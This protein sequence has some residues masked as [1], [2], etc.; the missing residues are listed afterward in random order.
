MLY[1]NCPTCGN[2]L[3]DKQLIYRNEYNEISRNTKMTEEEK[4]EYL[5]DLI[6]NVFKLKRYCCK[7]R[8]DKGTDETDVLV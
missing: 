7:M 8:I 2:K 1:Y 3:A 4:D 5:M 6:T